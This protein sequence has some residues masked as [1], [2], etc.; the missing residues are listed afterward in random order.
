MPL[1]FHLF[2]F[3]KDIYNAIASAT[4]IASGVPFNLSGAIPS[5]TGIYPLSQAHPLP[6]NDSVISGTAAHLLNSDTGSFHNDNTL[7]FSPNPSH[8]TQ[9]FPSNSLNCLPYNPTNLSGSSGFRAET[10][11]DLLYT[12]SY[13]PSSSSSSTSSMSSQQLVKFPL[14]NST[15]QN[16]SP[17]GSIFSLSDPRDFHLS[18]FLESN[19]NNNNMKSYNSTCQPN[20]LTNRPVHNSMGINFRNLPPPVFDE[21][22]CRP[23]LV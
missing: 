19:N 18:N 2:L 16:C 5:L 20:P 4:A 6:S 13:F 23:N 14:Y 21:I 9:N 12:P 17:N 7:H 3:L 8:L 15:N 11:S 1:I 22:I 10:K